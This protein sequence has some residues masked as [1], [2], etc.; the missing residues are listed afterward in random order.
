MSF[1]HLFLQVK[2]GGAIPAGFSFLT[3]MCE[4]IVDRRPSA[5]C[6]DVRATNPATSDYTVFTPASG[7]A[8][9]A[10]A[11]MCPGRHAAGSAAAALPGATDPGIQAG[12]TEAAIRQP[13][14]YQPGSR[15]ARDVA[16]GCLGG[17]VGPPVRVRGD[18][19][20]RREVSVPGLN[21]L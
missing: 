14:R 18:H 2:A 12:R 3:A 7:A 17:W 8:C 1:G 20:P 6:V 5:S 10:I 15:T 4:R 11:A 19:G 16:V 9:T 21:L 13:F